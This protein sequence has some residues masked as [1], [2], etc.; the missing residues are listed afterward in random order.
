[1][2]AAWW[3]LSWSWPVSCWNL[4]WRSFTTMKVVLF[5]LHICS[6]FFCFA[7]WMYFTFVPVIFFI[8]RPTLL[9]L[10]IAVYNSFISPQVGVV[11]LEFISYYG[12]SECFCLEAYNLL[13]DINIS[14]YW[15]DKFRSFCIIY[16]YHL[17]GNDKLL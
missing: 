17:T 9:S 14:P 7:V 10:N 4:C 13:R 16:K 2:V 8:C 6:A 12:V 15:K 3:K 5:S 1:M 11:R